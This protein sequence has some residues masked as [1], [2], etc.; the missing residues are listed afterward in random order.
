VTSEARRAIATI[1]EC[2]QFDRYAVTAHFA[3]RMAQRG[4]FWPDVGAIIKESSDM[5]SEGMDRYNRPKWIICGA[6]VTGEEVETVCAVEID[7]T[8]TEFITIYWES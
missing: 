6:F 3:K 4:L 8:E 2:I 7:E 1:R 5:R